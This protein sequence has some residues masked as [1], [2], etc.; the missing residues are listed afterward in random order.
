MSRLPRCLLL[1]VTLVLA[2][3]ATS[4]DPVPTGELALALRTDAPRATV[5]TRLGHRIT[6]T[7]PAPEVADHAWQIAWHDHRYLRQLGPLGPGGDG[8]GPVIAFLALRPG[9]T[10]VRFA[11]LPVKEAREAVP[12][13]LQEVV[14]RIE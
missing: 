10:R 7:L 5:A 6:L 9:T 4:R 11:L 12:A 2:G 13:G 8:A 14:L 1:L 3:C